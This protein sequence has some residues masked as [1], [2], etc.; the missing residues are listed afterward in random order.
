MA[1]TKA[2]GEAVRRGRLTKAVTFLEQAEVVLALADDEE[3][4][5]DAAVTLLVHAGIAASDVICCARLGE[6]A[7]GESHND[8]IALLATADQEAAKHLKVLLGLKTQA[9]Y[10][11]LRTTASNL[12]RANRAAVHL[13]D[14]ARGVG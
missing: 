6:H 1:R 10:R 14:A 5:A 9:G 7:H 13:V 3:D 2:C 4:V 11:A 12:K 8:A